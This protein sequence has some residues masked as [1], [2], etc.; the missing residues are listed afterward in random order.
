ML[1]K[2]L[3]R[4]EYTFFPTKGLVVCYDDP[5][6]ENVFD[7]RTSR[8]IH[9]RHTLHFSPA[10]APLQPPLCLQLH[11]Q[12]SVSSQSDQG[13]EKLAI[14]LRSPSNQSSTQFKWQ[15]TSAISKEQTPPP[16]TPLLTCKTPALSRFRPH[17]RVRRNAV[18]QANRPST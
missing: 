13:P 3:H 15:I 1:G 9:H 4:N 14:S 6:A 16:L 7:L 2:A 8:E 5:Q 17:L 12:S 11:V 10:A 18:M